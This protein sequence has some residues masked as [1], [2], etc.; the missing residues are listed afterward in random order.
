MPKHVPHTVDDMINALEKYG[1]L[2]ID[3]RHDYSGEHD[4]CVLELTNGDEFSAFVS[5][6]THMSEAL[7]EMLDEVYF[8]M[9]TE[10][11]SLTGAHLNQCYKV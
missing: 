10:V 1:T 2:R 7:S 11:E 3:D 6:E 5:I 9:V 8:T 4:Y